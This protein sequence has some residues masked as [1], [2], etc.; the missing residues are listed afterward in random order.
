MR[1]N[2]WPYQEAELKT[3]ENVG[4]NV[5][6]WHLADTPTVALNVCFRGKADMVIALQNDR[7]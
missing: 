1:E 4:E 3:Q 7:L 5:C 6:L 2:I